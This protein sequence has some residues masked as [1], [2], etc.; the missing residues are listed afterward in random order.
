MTLP[1]E[2]DDDALELQRDELEAISAMFGDDVTILSES[3]PISYSIKL[4]PANEEVEDASIW[5]RDVNL[6]LSIL[7]PANYPDEAA[8]FG[9]SYSDVNL[10]LHSIQENAA[11]NHINTVAESELGT[12]CILNCYYAA[13]DFIN[14]LGLIQA[15]L[16]IL[17]D[18][19]LASVLSYLAA[20]KE[21]VDI[22]VAALP[23]FAGVYRTDIVWKQICCT[24]WKQKW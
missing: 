24:S 5:P 19:C 12:P 22:A 11:L 23:L 3:Y 1:L 21:D 10:K 18:D 6:A 4:R 8:I 16:A 9:L 20:S 17:S 7:Y 15:A 2:L 13:R 14:N